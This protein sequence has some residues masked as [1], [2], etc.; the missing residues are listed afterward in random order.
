MKPARKLLRDIGLT[1]TEVELYLNLLSRHPVGVSELVKDTGIQRTTVYHALETLMQKGFVAK[2]GSAARLLFSAT[3]PSY[4]EKYMAQ[5]I[6]LLKDQSDAISSLIP[7]LQKQ[8]DYESGKVIVSHFEGI[9]GI[10]MVVEEAL[11]CKSRT[12]DIVAPRRN[13]FSEFDDAYA[14]YF[15]KTRLKNNIVARSLWEKDLSSRILSSEE[16]KRR[17]PRLLPQTMQ[18]KFKSVIILFDD[19]VALI[20]SYK[21]KSAILIQSKE[22][23]ETMS[24]LFDGLWTCAETYPLKK[25]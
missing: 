10:K 15:I 20:S 8:G 5:K 12:W 3:D 25:D 13:F 6:V 16:I 14:S 21:E 9:E 19:K 24:A 4:L 18:G 2:R 22:F 11:W 23:F 7:L 1:D 17:N